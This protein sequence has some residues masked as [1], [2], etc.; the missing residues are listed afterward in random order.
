[1][2]EIPLIPSDEPIDLVS[3][4]ADLGA[5][6]VET[7]NNQAAIEKRT[8]DF[9]AAAST[10]HNF[11]VDA[12]FQKVNED[13]LPMQSEKD[14]YRQA[15]RVEDSDSVVMYIARKLYFNDLK[16]MDL[17]ALSEVY[18]LPISELSDISL[19]GIPQLCLHFIESNYLVDSGRR[20]GEG[21][22]KGIRLMKFR[23]NTMKDTEAKA[24]AKKIKTVFGSPFEWKK[25]KNMLS[26]SDYENGY[27]LQILCETKEGGKNVLEKVLAIQDH[28]IVQKYINY[29]EN[30]SPE[31]AYP[32]TPQNITILEKEVKDVDR[33]PIV[34]VSF[35][36]SYLYL[37]NVGK[38]RV[39]Y[40]KTNRYPNAYVN[41]L[42]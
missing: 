40:D 4:S 20:I 9:F 7:I 39:L 10:L 14:Y 22:I 42:G 2:E 23:A 11:L 24:L 1:M 28:T 8:V 35:R 31:E 5:D 6:D 34:S 18:M 16:G 32:D 33:R 13:S 29:K 3:P 12:Y 19:S 41:D 30:D 36:V 17:D 37:R 15:S 26:Y 25:G 27:N 21:K 38:P